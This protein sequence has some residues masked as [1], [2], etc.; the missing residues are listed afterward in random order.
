L[1]LGVVGDDRCIERQ[2]LVDGSATGVPLARYAAFWGVGVLVV[3]S[4]FLLWQL[5]AAL[6][7][8]LV[9]L[10]VSL[11]F[12]IVLAPAVDFFQTR[13]HLRR[14]L[15]TAVVFLIG[16][17]VFGAIGYAFAR[18]V[19]DASTSFADELPD[20]IRDAEEGRGDIGRWL[21]DIG[22]QDWARENLP[23]IRQSLGS[24][25]G[26]LLNAG[27]AVVT[28]VVA[29]LTIAVLTFLMLL[30]AP[31]LTASVVALLPERRAE[32]VVRVGGDAARAVTGYVTGNLAISLIAGLFAYG[33]LRILG[34]PFAFILALW[35]AFADLLP[36]VGA[37]LG[38]I[39]PVFVAFLESPGRGIATIIFFVV[40]QQFENHVLQ[41]VVMSRTVKLNPLAVLVAVLVG[42]QL[43]GL[44]G[45]LLAI[46]VAGA[47]QVVVRDVWDER[48]G[49]VKEV[50][51]VGAD[52]TP[53]NDEASM[54]P[55]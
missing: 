3:G 49:T 54:R 17:G 6:G 24:D 48:R 14:V 53:I 42:V 51:S 32:H 12:T 9:L 25:S 41:P 40:Y 37:T 45:A 21:Q 18:P 4:T 20:T 16:V 11:F 10:A 36:L 50:L 34:V 29:V 26:T 1:L 31:Q 38:A 55:K 28:G 15:A 47:L 8:V 35:V 33:W 5:I 39:P 22:A 19:Y 23:K 44:L 27:R 2:R 52:E 46:P 7:E 43:A 30:Q 13:A